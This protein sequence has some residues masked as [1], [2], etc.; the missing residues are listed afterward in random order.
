MT[1]KLAFIKKMSIILS[2]VS[3][4]ST[5]TSDNYICICSSRLI[6]ISIASKESNPN[7]YSLFCFRFVLI[8]FPG[9]LEP[10]LWGRKRLGLNYLIVWRTLA[11]IYSRSGTTEGLDVEVNVYILLNDKYFANPIYPLYIV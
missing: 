11:V 6:I 10:V 5:S 2:I 1:R 3:S 7:Y 9:F 8:E 4:L